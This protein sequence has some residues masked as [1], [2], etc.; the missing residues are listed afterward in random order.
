MVV[1]VHVKKCIAPHW[2]L[3]VAC[4][5]IIVNSEENHRFAIVAMVGAVLIVDVVDEYF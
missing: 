5:D 4:F 1:S 2:A 3:R